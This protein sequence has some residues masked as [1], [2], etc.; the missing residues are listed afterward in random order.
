MVEKHLHGNGTAAH[1]SAS[2]GLLAGASVLKFSL[3]YPNVIIGNS[4]KKTP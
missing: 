2:V 4:Q 1:T 3:P